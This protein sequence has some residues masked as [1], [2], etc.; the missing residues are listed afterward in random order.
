MK[1]GKQTFAGYIACRISDIGNSGF[2]PQNDIR[3]CLKIGY[4]PKMFIFSEN[5]N[6]LVGALEHGFYILGNSS[7]Q[8]TNSMIFQ[9]VGR[10]TTKQLSIGPLGMPGNAPVPDKAEADQRRGGD[11]FI[12]LHI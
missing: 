12:Y 10:K 4:I 9:R 11:V 2:R 6:Y 3:V 7:S 1:L 5:D 8:L